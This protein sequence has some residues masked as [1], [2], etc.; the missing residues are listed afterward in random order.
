[1]SKITHFGFNDPMGPSE[2]SQYRIGPSVSEASRLVTEEVTREESRIV[3]GL[4]DADLLSRKHETEA[5]IEELK[6]RLSVINIDYARRER[7]NADAER[8]ALVQAE[9][10][11]QYVRRESLLLAD[12]IE[13]ELKERYPNKIREIRNLCKEIV[14]M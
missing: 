10:Q 9:K 6:I 2:R 5:W 3:A 4:T 13:R 14:K 11:Y 1:M 7:E 12:E 8:D